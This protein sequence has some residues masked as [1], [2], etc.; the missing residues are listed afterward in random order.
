MKEV[1]TQQ[2]LDVQE[3]LDNLL[4][5]DD[6]KS[7]PEFREGFK[8]LLSV[9][10]PDIFDINSWASEAS[11]RDLPYEANGKK[12]VGTYDAYAGPGKESSGFI[13]VACNNCPVRILCLGYAALN[14]ETKLGV[15][16]GMKPM[17]RKKF[18]AK[19]T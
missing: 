17:E 14:P 10:D 5:I 4:A 9:A 6:P 15:W 7:N 1:N 11:C 18:L 3:S 2:S 19:I 13:E 8:D 12:Q 16:G